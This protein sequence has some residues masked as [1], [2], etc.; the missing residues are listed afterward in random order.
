MNGKEKKIV[1]EWKRLLSKIVE[2]LEY[3]KEG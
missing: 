2:V 3:L 1:N